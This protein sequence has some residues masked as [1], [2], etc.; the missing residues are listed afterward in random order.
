M[1]PAPVVRAS[2]P[3]P[4]RL[5]IQ[6]FGT[7][8]PTL[9]KIHWSSIESAPIDGL[10]PPFFCIWPEPID[11]DACFQSAGFS[12]FADSDELWD[13]EFNRLVNDLF[14]YLREFGS[15]QIVHGEL[16][17]ERHFLHQ[18]IGSIQDAL[19]CA[20]TDDQFPPCVI[21]FGN[22]TRAA[23]AATDGH[24][25]FWL[26]GLDSPKSL[27]AAVARG[28]ECTQTTLTWSAIWPS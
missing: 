26:G 6:A 13:A 11:A 14:L 16:P 1:G 21:G 15:P 25:I 8:M 24:P 12:A 2:S 23:I 7:I 27:L 4:P 28:R 3:H 9:R 22:P 20:A 19:V 17:V 5:T 18:R 10:P